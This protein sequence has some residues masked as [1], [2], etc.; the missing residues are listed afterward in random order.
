MEHHIDTVDHHPVRQPPCRV[1]F[2]LH[3]TVAKLI[4]EMLEQGVTVPSS[5]LWAS[6]IVRV[7]KKD[8]ST[9][10]Y[11]DCRKLNATT[12]LNVFPLPQINNSLDLLSG[13]RYF[14]SLDLASGYWQVGMAPDSQEK[15]AFTTNTGLYEFTVM[16]LGLCNAPATFQ[17]LMENVLAGLARDKC[18]VYL[19]DIL[20]IRQTFKEHL[21]NLREVFSRLQRTGLKLKP[22]KCKLLQ[23][24][25]DFLGHVVS[26]QGI[27]AD[28]KKVMVVTEFLRPTDLR[29]LRAF[30]GLTSYYHCFVP[31][32][33]TVA[34]PLYALT[35][36][37]VPFK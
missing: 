1:P 15:T 7:M 35:R 19:D 21:A 34:Y 8:G 16:P 17:W 6:P 25:V 24:E 3:D 32:F 9:R 5:S 27:G 22:T 36:K 11:V 4:E 20:V 28:P 29:A 10:F 37:D 26:H 12:K 31:C 14:T 13:T 33:P 2:A 23:K 18:L 30:L